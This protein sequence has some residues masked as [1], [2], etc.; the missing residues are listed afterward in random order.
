[1]KKETKDFFVVFNRGKAYH[2][3]VSDAEK[4]IIEEALRRS[5]GNQTIAS[6]ILGINRNTLR[7]KIKKFNIDISEFKI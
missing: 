5:F 2:E 7:F 3:V 6:K 4:A 1:M